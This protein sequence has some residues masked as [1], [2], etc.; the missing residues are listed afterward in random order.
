MNRRTLR[1]LA[2]TVDVLDVHCSKCSRRGRLNVA[3]L[4]GRY[5]NDFLITNLRTTLN[6]GCEHADSVVT[7]RCDLYFPQL[8][9]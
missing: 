5:G 1:D 2:T 9:G 7:L 6:A 4:A 8:A 3:K